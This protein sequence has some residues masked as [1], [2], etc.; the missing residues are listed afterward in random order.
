MPC[1]RSR[2]FSVSVRVST[3]ESKPAVHME[4]LE[5]GQHGGF[6]NRERIPAFERTLSHLQSI[7]SLTT[8]RSAHQEATGRTNY[9]WSTYYTEDIYTDDS[10]GLSPGCTLPAHVLQTQ[11]RLNLLVKFK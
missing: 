5:P 9:Q 6:G 3:L 4:R 7:S 8:E 1:H 10:A 2:M 11:K